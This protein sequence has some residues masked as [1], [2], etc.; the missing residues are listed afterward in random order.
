M[1]K[2]IYVSNSQ[3]RDR[4]SQKYDVSVI[5][6]DAPN[7]EFIKGGKYFTHAEFECYIKKHRPRRISFVFEM[8]DELECVIDLVSEFVVSLH[9]LSKHNKAFDL[10]PLEGCTELEAIQLYW[11]IKQK[12]LWDISQNK[13]LKNF[14]ITNYYNVSDLAVLGKSSVEIL[15]IFGC[16]GGS[17]VSKMHIA[18]FSFVAEMPR[19]K[20]LHFDII[21]DEPGEYYLN[22]LSKCTG[23][24]RLYTTRNFFTFQQF[25]WL[26]SRLP[27]VKHGLECVLDGGGFQSVIGKKTPKYLQD[28]IKAA[29]YQRRYDSL[30]EKYKTRD[31]PPSDSEKD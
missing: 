3:A 21:K 13:K 17:F 4:Y 28:P 31:N 20:E 11:N 19:L 7:N 24:E 15:R 16:D 2:L 14:E 29:E 30:I 5:F 18:D 12:T 10:S 23:L 9:L 27:N 8:Q 26:Q 1:R 25:A 22:I 6:T